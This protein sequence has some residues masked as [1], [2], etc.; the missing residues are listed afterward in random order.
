MSLYY[1]ERCGHVTN[2]L[3]L[4]KVDR[5]PLLSGFMLGF[6]TG[7]CTKEQVGMPPRRWREEA[8]NHRG[9]DHRET[10]HLART[11]LRLISKSPQHS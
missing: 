3:T 2:L 11:Q 10:F 1:D 7:M 4:K 9:P 5:W 8:Q 6:G